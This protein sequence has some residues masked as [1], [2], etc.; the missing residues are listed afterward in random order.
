MSKKV[1][2]KLKIGCDP[3]FTIA[4][5]GKAIQANITN[6]LCKYTYADKEHGEIGM[7]VGMAELRPKPEN[8]I[9]SLTKNIKFLLTK[10]S[11]KIGFMQWDT[12]S[13]LAAVGGHI[14]LELPK[15]WLNLNASDYKVNDYTRKL[16]S[17][18]LPIWLSDD[19]KKTN[20]VRGNTEDLRA[21]GHYGDSRIEQKSSGATT[22]E[23]RTP[24]AQWLTCPK[25]TLAVFAYLACI[26]NEIIYHPETFKNF[27]DIIVK[28]KEE[29]TIIE[30]AAKLKYSMFIDPLLHKIKLAVK[31]FELYP[32]FKREINWL[33][34]S[35]AVQ[36]EKEKYNWDII[37]GWNLEPKDI[38]LCILNNE[39]N[40][41]TKMKEFKNNTFQNNW[42]SLVPFK[43]TDDTNIPTWTHELT[44]KMYLLNW[45]IK[46]SY[47]FY[48]FKKGTITEAVVSDKNLNIHIGKTALDTEEKLSQIKHAIKKMVNR[49]NSQGQTYIVG[50]PYDIR[51]QNDIN[52]LTELV[53]FM[54]H[55]LPLDPTTI[56]QEEK[57]KLMSVKDAKEFT[58]KPKEASTDTIKIEDKRFSLKF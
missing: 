24:S 54:E 40:I 10:A 3:E 20:H 26:H 23:L 56:T 29:F 32:E 37:K 33:F 43:Y 55:N 13:N 36:K 19:F 2:L 12:S 46:R 35:E 39:K 14:H 31:K 8:D 16:F 53:H 47:I 57:D 25:T 28:N 30:K 34:T 4:L 44:K 45:K 58:P 5:N 21:Y 42:S 15:E 11:E 7:D 18:Y 48:G 1:T 49:Y 9:L 22:Y 27:P 17:F 41:E 51:K 52:F 38:T 6:E 50:I